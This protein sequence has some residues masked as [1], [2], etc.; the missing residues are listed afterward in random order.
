MKSIVT[1]KA[2]VFRN[3][4]A[5][6]LLRLDRKVTVF[7]Y[8]YRLQLETFPYVTRKFPL[9]KCDLGVVES[10]AGGIKSEDLNCFRF[11]D[12]PGAL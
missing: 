6:A 11:S 4:F 9:V 8:L 7:E 12:G 3:Y 10:W 5:E 2:G 1:G